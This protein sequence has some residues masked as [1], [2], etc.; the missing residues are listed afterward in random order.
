[1]GEP[2]EVAALALFCVQMK[3]AH[4]GRRLFV[5]GG[6][7]NLRGEHGSAIEGQSHHRYGGPGHWRGIVRACA[8][9]GPYP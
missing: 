1:M 7:I 6:F 2:E 8:A 5:D 9:E 4:H 3:P